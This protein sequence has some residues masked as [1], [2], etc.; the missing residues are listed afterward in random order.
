MIAPAARDPFRSGGLAQWLDGRPLH[1][2]TTS[3]T[4]FP[5]RPTSI[6]AGAPR[7]GTSETAPSVAPTA[8]IPRK[9]RVQNARIEDRAP[10]LSNSR[11][12]GTR[13]NLDHEKANRA[14]ELA[15]NATKAQAS[16][17]RIG[18]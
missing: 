4:R 6:T 15:S 9:T 16:A 10:S 17:P 5:A 11:S 1:G 12:T 7:F 13:P 3:Q 14:R 18:P 2:R 8:A